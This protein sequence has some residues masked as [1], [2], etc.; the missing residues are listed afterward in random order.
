MTLSKE[1]LVPISLWLNIENTLIQDEFLWN[2][3]TIDNF[4]LNRF[5]LQILSEKLGRH[6][7]G[8]L[9]NYSR[10]KFAEKVSETIKYNANLYNSL[11]MDEWIGTINE[12]IGMLFV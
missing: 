10:Y 4:T 1:S 8:S 7:F 2:P 12:S 9:D 6:Q 5:G 3:K 11:N